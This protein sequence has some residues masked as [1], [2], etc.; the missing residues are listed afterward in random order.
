M[1]IGT[2]GLR[3]NLYLYPSPPQI[4]NEMYACGQGCQ[5]QEGSKAEAPHELYKTEISPSWFSNYKKKSI[6]VKV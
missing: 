3:V 1:L 6:F 5:V 4:F 2:Y